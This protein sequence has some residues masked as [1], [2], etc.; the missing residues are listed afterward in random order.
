ME[1]MG[2]QLQLLGVPE[3]H[4]FMSHKACIRPDIP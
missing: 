1:K 3:Q 2:Q 4:S